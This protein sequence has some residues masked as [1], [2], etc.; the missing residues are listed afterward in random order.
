MTF[1]FTTISPTSEQYLRLHNL[2]FQGASVT[3]EWINW[4]HM[5]I[6]KPT[7][8]ETV[9][10]AAFDGDVLVGIWSVEPKSIWSKARI[11]HVGRCFSVGIHP[12]YRRLGL[13]VKLS[14]FAIASEKKRGV[15]D[16]IL[17]F[18][19]KGRSVISGHLKA[20]WEIIHEVG[21][22]SADIVR[23]PDYSLSKIERIIDF[24]DLGPSYRLEG[25]IVESNQYRN[26]RWLNHP[27][28]HYITLRCNSA[29]IVL[30]IYSNFCHILSL[31]GDKSEVLI[32]LKTARNLAANHGLVEINIW[33]SDNDYF[34][35]EIIAAGFSPGS[36]FGSPIS[37][38]AV[39]I[40]ETSQLVIDSCHIEMGVE[41]GY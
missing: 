31:N 36:N 32:L 18:P 37:L 4:Y 16:Y 11:I 15:F 23:V 14:K 40:N 28:H 34:K 20:G 8:L 25:A 35:D 19:Q 29:Y 1:T 2:L 6:P 41:E 3:R 39:K 13:F 22:Y 9:T 26:M 10:Y 17:G 27:D 24:N 7:Y 30:K 5:E 38:I 21:I 33:C 12:D